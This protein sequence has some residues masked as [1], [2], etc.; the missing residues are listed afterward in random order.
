MNIYIH[1]D[2]TL[3]TY[4]LNDR[5][6][7]NSENESGAAQL[8]DDDGAAFIIHEGTDDYRSQPSGDA[9]KRIAC[10]VIKAD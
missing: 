5:M 9:G 6:T 10:A 7:L 4:I 8:L 2:G 3:E 1:Q